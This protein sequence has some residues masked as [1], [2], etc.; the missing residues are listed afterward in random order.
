MN[1]AVG[2][3]KGKYVDRTIRNIKIEISFF[4]RAKIISDFFFLSL[5]S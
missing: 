1:C 2:V 4:L 5:I 3:S